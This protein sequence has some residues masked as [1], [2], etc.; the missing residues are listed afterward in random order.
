MKLVNIYS[1]IVPLHNKYGVILTYGWA[2][3]IYGKVFQLTYAWNLGFKGM[4][5]KYIDIYPFYYSLGYMVGPQCF[6]I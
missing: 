5:L 1:F 3:K 6:N 2:H 4:N